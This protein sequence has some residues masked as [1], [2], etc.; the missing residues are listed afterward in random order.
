MTTEISNSRAAVEQR[1]RQWHGELDREVARIVGILSARP[2]VR[3][4][5][6]FGS[7]G[8]GTPRYRSDID[9]VVVEETDLRYPDRVEELYRLLRPRIQTDLVVYTPDEW[10]SDTA[11]ARF[12]NRVEKEGRV[13]YAT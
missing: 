11:S 3:Q 8:R 9:L 10:K 4:V 2:A 1:R 12:R 5:V 6:L 13:L 7:L